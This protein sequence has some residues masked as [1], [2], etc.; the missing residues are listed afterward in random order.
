MEA[1]PDGKLQE[2]SRSSK[3]MPEFAKTL[4]LRCAS[5]GFLGQRLVPPPES[6]TVGFLK[7]KF[8]LGDF[9]RN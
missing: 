6:C 4:R 7:E 9:S 1:L 5:E 8:R 3:G 2:P